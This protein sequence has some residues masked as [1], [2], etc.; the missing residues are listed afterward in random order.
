MARLI[1]A[2]LGDTMARKLKT[3]KSSSKKRTLCIVKRKGHQ[4]EFDE[5]KVYA[6]C[7]RACLGAQLDEEAC[8]RICEKVCSELNGWVR[9]T[10]T[11]T[12][13][14]IFL[15]TVKAMRKHNKAAAFMYETHRDIA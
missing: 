11:T 4:E 13:H 15:H 12:S 10:R 6:T 1:S 9:K 3:V 2:N 5:R 7:Y 8:E 14:E